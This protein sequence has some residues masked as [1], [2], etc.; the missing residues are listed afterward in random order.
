M[1]E[2]TTLTRAVTQDRINAYAAVSGDRN[3]IHIDA[4]FA[5]AT[6]FGGTIAHGMILFGYLSDALSRTYG[7]AWDE[8]GRLRAR[9]RSP[10]RPGD[11]LSITVQER[12][13]ETR[14]DGTI[15]VRCGVECSKAGTAERLATGD[16]TLTV[17]E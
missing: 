14:S 13:R 7:A 1:T 15:E 3:R 10:A 9:F 8:S 5:A 2:N 11:Q 6:Q 17:T 16:A 4:D 12:V